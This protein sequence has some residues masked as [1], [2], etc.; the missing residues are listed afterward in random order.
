MMA[1]GALHAAQEAGVDV[2]R[3]LSI[4]GFDDID[5][6]AYTMPPLT[7]VAQPK[8]AIGTETAR[9]LLERVRGE[10]GDARRTILQPELRV[11]ASTARPPAQ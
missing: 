4:V 10:R 8:E 3:A 2:P 5:L 9:L 1:I 6:A 11:R 7:T